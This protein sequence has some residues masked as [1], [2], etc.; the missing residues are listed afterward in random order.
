[1]TINDS[2][3]A[4]TCP[5]SMTTCVITITGATEAAHN[6]L[7]IDEGKSYPPAIL[8]RH[9]NELLV[10]VLEMLNFSRI[11]SKSSHLF[12]PVAERYASGAG[13]KWSDVGAELV[14]RRLQAIVRRSA[15]A[16]T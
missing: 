1:M 12:L 7:P 11:H 9:S 14:P 8:G 4:V 10:S 2:D 13:N 3:I 6:H 15:L 5:Q 16:Q